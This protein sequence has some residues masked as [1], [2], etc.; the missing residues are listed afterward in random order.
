MTR[1]KALFGIAVVSVVFALTGCGS[2]SKG[3]SSNP[4]PTLT[5]AASSGSVTSGQAVTLTWQ[6]TNAVSVS[7]T[8]TGADGTSRAISTNSKL[9]GTAQD[10]PTQDTTYSATAKASGGA[11]VQQQ[12]K[13]AVTAAPSQAATL[14]FSASAASITSGQSVT[15]TWTTTNATALTI[16][17]T[18]SD[19]TVRNIPTAQLN[20]SNQDSPTVT[21][22]Y[23]ATATGPGGDSKPQQVQVAVTQPP[24]TAPTLVFSASSNS[25]TKGDSVTLNWQTTNATSV[26]ITAVGADGVTRQIP[27][28]A[29]PATDQPTEDTTYTAI[30]TGPGGSTQ[31]QS[32]AVA[33]TLGVPQINQL[34]ANPTTVVAGSSTTLSWQT[35]NA[36]SVT[37]TPALPQGDPQDGGTYPASEPAGIQIP[38]PTTVTYT[39]VATGSGGQ[40]QPASVTINAVNINLTATPANSTA[41]QPVTL[42]WQV[43]PAVTTLSIDNGGC[44]PCTPL[45]K[46]SITV[47]PAATTTYTAT[48][49]LT[50]GTQLTQT[51]TVTVASPAAGKIKHIIFMLQ[52]NRSF[53]SYFGVLG[54]Y[55]AQRLQPFGITASSTDVDGFDPNVVL[56]NHH[57]GTQVKPFHE[58]TVCTQNPTPSWDESHHDLALNGGDKA[59]L[60]TSTYPAGSF[61]M[62]N[63]LDT[64]NGG[65]GG[66]ETNYDPEGTRALGYYDQTDLPYYYDLASFFATSDRWFAPIL[67][68]TYPNRMFIEA[69]SSFGHEYPD[70]DNT[71]P[72]YSAKTIYRAMNEANVSWAYYYQDGMFLPNFQ[73]YSDP[74]VQD[75]TYRT[76]SLLNLLAGTCNGSPCDPDKTLPQ[77]VFIESASGA[78]ALDEHPDNNIQKGAAYI[79][80]IIGALMKSDAW[81]DSVFILTYDESGGLYDHVPPLTVPPPDAYAQ[82]QCPDPNNG[83]YGYC[84]AGPNA[85]FTAPTPQNGGYNM[86]NITGLRLP[87][88]VV[89]PYVKPHYVSH[90]PMDS[91]AILAFI[92]KTFNVPPLTAR[93]AYWLKNGDM[94]DFFDFSTPADLNP[95]NSTGGGAAWTTFLPTQPTNGVCDKTKEAGGIVN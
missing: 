40:S 80:S 75:K 78:S 56:T 39:M 61:A 6:T 8:A 48:A 13:V 90:V 85:N 70:A 38:V 29:N 52:E 45:P 64:P 47:T 62:T 18:G 41:N 65:L 27:T 28:T 76:S 83:S 37:F 24:P 82:G 73:D 25:I 26:A 92:E 43:D 60:T 51:I 63:F 44:A 95:P 59:W 93:D 88:L 69:A 89:S 7:I 94:S 4:T 23:S 77:V 71:H 30:A 58:P 55:R 14:T 9:S 31:P 67:S 46:G 1:L 10:S 87:V 33:V 86:F 79:Q 36:N 74:T 72:R 54:A 5:F 66:N 53:D 32:V 17:A 91:T 68:A 35:T 20:G 22:T 49:T 2:S 42:S 81:Q 21:T 57:D 15:L 84:H 12:V 19:G 11:S 34:T 50:D 16:T 3:S